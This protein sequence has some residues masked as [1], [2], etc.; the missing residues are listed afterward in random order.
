MID[1]K[2]LIYT[3]TFARCDC[4]S[5]LVFTCLLDFFENE[6]FNFD[7]QNSDLKHMNHHLYHHFVECHPYYFLQYIGDEIRKKRI[8]EYITVGFKR[9]SISNIWRSNIQEQIK[10]NFDNL[11]TT[12]EIGFQ[13]SVMESSI[14][15]KFKIMKY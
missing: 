1:R 11:I 10:E 3:Y 2:S 14:L 5:K 8:W 13:K 4:L 6:I 7:V 9:I 15:W 12:F